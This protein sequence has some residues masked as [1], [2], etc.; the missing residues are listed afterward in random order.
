[1]MARCQLQAIIVALCVVFTGAFAACESYE[2]AGVFRIDMFNDVCLYAEYIL[3]VEYQPGYVWRRGDRL[4]CRPEKCAQLQ[5]GGKELVYVCSVRDAQSFPEDLKEIFD[6][7]SGYVPEGLRH[8]QDYIPYAYDLVPRRDAACAAIAGIKSVLSGKACIFDGKLHP[9]FDSWARYFFQRDRVV[10]DSDKAIA[11]VERNGQ[12][13]AGSVWIRR[14]LVRDVLCYYP[15]AGPDWLYYRCDLAQA[16]GQ[17]P[18]TWHNVVRRLSDFA[19]S[20][21]GACFNDSKAVGVVKVVLS[22]CAAFFYEKVWCAWRWLAEESRILQWAMDK[23]LLRGTVQDRIYQKG[24]AWLERLGTNRGFA[25]FYRCV[26][27]TV[28]RFMPKFAC[29]KECD[30]LFQEDVSAQSVLILENFIKDGL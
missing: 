28:F 26:D 9:Y 7:V 12:Y 22:G 25:L 21:A 16:Y 10:K 15:E 11:V 5:A 29:P 30:Y 17:W 3:R 1:M 13:Q 24:S 23:R 6:L 20:E 18:A 14:E 4:Y 19:C 8:L 2:D 27:G